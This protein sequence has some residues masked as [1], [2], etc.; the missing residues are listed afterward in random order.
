MGCLGSEIVSGE[1]RM[2]LSG[3]TPALWMQAGVGS[4]KPACVRIA[5]SA[6]TDEG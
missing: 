2:S 5:L 4:I 1:D 3:C 6:H